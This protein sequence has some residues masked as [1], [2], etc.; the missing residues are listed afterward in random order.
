MSYLFECCKKCKHERS[1][2]CHSRCKRYKDDLEELHKRK[3]HLKQNTK[4]VR[5]KDFN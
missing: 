4:V 3:E 5:M 1:E 2:N